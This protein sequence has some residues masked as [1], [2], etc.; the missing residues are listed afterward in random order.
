MKYYV[1]LIKYLDKVMYVG[2]TNNITH[3]KYHHLKCVGTRYSAVPIDVDLQY[4]EFVVDSEFDNNIDAVIYEEE[5][6][7]KYD[8]INNGWNRNR[9][10]YIS[11]DMKAYYKKRNQKPERKEW[12]VKYRKSD[13]YKGYLKEYYHTEKYK[14][15]KRNYA[16]ERYHRLKEIALTK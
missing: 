12:C 5:L 14:E 15:Y 2:K 8:T 13:K 6:I 10:G 1:Y 3:R 4:I 11:E 16:R 7:L 9:S